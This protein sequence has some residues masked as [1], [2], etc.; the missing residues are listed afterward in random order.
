VITLAHAP[1][2]RQR[3][4]G[5][6]TRFVRCQEYRDR[7]YIIR[8]SGPPKRRPRDKLLFELAADNAR[9]M[10]ALSIDRAW[11]D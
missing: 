1:R 7:R 8:L 4:A 10:C 5:D 6:P 3:I 11:V 9:S 2:N